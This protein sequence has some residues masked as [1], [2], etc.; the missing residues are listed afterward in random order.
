MSNSSTPTPERP[1]ELLDIGHQCSDPSCNLHDFLPFKCQHCTQQFCAEHFKPEAHHCEKYDET[2]HN[3]VAPSCPLCNTPV[4][5][6]P[7][8]DPNVRMERHI[9]TEC[10]VMT[11]KTKT[12][13]TPHCARAKCGKHRFPKDHSCSSTASPSKPSPS[14]AT[15]MNAAGAA[16]MAAIKRFNN[17]SS[18]ATPSTSRPSAQ[19]Q[20][21]KK[22]SIPTEASSAESSPS[23]PNLFSKTDRRAKSERDSRRKAMQERAKKGLLSE[24]EKAILAAEEAEAARKKQDCI[25]A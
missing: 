23:K 21:A 1:A 24:E 19:H 6:P 5:I 17:S 10:S 11:G 16:A 2:K 8:Q 3:R 18:N 7:G 25:I 14:P 15:Q 20:P 12:S 22:T 4:A 9:N 13:S